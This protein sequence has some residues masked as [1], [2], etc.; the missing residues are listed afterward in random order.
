VPALHALV[1][2]HIKKAAEINKCNPKV[3][4][5]QFAVGSYVYVYVPKRVK[6]RKTEGTVVNKLNDVTYFVRSKGRFS[7]HQ[8]FR[9]YQPGDSVECQIIYIDQN[10]CRSSSK[11]VNNGK[12]ESCHH[13]QSLSLSFYTCGQCGFCSQDSK[14][15]ICGGMCD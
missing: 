3:K 13:Y 11:L 8:L 14:S 15:Q 5:Q 2:G 4:P 7:L 1:R 9:T 10:S 12:T 6:E